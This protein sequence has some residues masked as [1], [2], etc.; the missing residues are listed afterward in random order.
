MQHLSDT[1]ELADEYC[2]AE[3]RY[4]SSGKVEQKINKKLEGV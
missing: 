1:Q 3:M 4:F 2:Y